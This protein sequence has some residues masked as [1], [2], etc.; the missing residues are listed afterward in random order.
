MTLPIMNTPTYTLELVSN[1]KSITYRPFLVKEEK[2]LLMALEGG[3]EKEM[4]NAT[5]NI[6]SSCVSSDDFNINNIPLFEIQYIFLQIRA[7]S[8]GNI[9]EVN[10]R[11]PNGKNKDGQNC[12]GIQT[13]SIDLSEIKPKIP[14]GHSKKIQLTNDI[15]V[16]MKYPTMNFFEKLNK[17][18]EQ[19]ENAVNAIFE[20]ITD[21]IDYIYQGENNYYSNE[22]S[23]EE[24]TE[25][26]NNLNSQQF[27][28]IR[29]FF[30]TMPVISHEEKFKCS[31][32]GSEEVLT[33]NGIDDFFA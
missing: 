7:K 32:C 10:L 30:S 26:V 4:I 17:L 13:I 28:K 9:V 31:K 29:N 16:V 5:K 3:D 22:Y 27:E 1:N 21:S 23:K 19:N 14:Q 24:L 6:I 2:I 20:V 12:D 11:H 25:F 15:G 33:L 8:V 18:D